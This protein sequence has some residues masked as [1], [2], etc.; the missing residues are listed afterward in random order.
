MTKRIIS[1]FVIAMLLMGLM[2]LMAG[3]KDDGPLTPEEA[4]EIVMED[5]GIDQS[6]VD[7][8][9]THV[10]TVNGVACYVVYITVDGE[11]MQYLIDGVSGEIL[12]KEETDTGHHH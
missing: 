7:S 9:D 3:C 10:T 2:G 6:D 11:H 4:M 12:T 1:L 8:I 5:M